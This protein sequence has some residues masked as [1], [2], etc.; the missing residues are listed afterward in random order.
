MK[1]LLI[2]RHGKAEVHHALGD[3]ERHLTNR[4]V[5]DA[6][7]MGTVIGGQGTLDTIISSDAERASQTARLV[8]EAAKYSGRILFR[9]EIYD[10]TL[11]TMLRL[12]RCLPEAAQTALIVGHN[13]G[14]Q[15][16]VAELTDK[17][18]IECSL[19]TCGLAAVYFDGKWQDIIG[20]A[21]RLDGLWEAR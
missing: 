21:G 14:F 16:L 17:P 8:A 2:L 6:Q 9:P 19:P 7:H 11:A 4:G 10:A 1:K 5:I 13:P 20:G 18:L 3:K 15:E 12:V